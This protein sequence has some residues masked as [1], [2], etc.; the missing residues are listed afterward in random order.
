MNLAYKDDMAKVRVKVDT[1][2]LE[3]KLATVSKNLNRSYKI[4]LPK[5]I[6][7]FIRKGI[8]PVKGHGRFAPYSFSYKSQIKGQSAYRRGKNGGLFMVTTL[9]DIDREDARDNKEL[10]KE[11]NKEFLSHGKRVSPRNLTLSG[12]MLKSITTNETSN[13]LLIGFTDEKAAYHDE[14]EG[15]LPRRAMLPTRK[16]EIFNS[17]ITLRMREVAKKAILKIF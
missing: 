3:R 7:K 5:L 17:S 9:G 10:I 6:L 11:M 15:N 16:G 4:F 2:N 12:K 14:G 8:S 1:R 13:S